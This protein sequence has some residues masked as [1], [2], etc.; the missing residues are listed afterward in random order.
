MTFVM[1]SDDNCSLR[2]ARVVG[3]ASKT[4]LGH[5][6]G[7]IRCRYI[8]GVGHRDTETRPFLIHPARVRAEYED[9]YPCDSD[10]HNYSAAMLKLMALMGRDTQGSGDAK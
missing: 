8:N 3:K 2:V 4:I 9:E 7:M 1:L 5:K 6:V 10:R